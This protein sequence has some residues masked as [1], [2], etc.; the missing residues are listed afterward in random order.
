MIH[1][2]PGNCE[3]NIVLPIKKTCFVLCLFVGGGVIK[4]YLWLLLL[5]M[6]IKNKL[7]RATHNYDERHI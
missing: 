5:F 1:E 7:W 2:L 3:Y 6:E 4:M